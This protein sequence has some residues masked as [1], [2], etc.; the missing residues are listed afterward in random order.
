MYKAKA[1]SPAVVGIVGGGHRR[2]M[3]PLR[4]FRLRYDQA[5]LTTGSTTIN[6]QNNMVAVRRN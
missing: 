1:D 2:Y 6:S 5:T 4:A 3:A